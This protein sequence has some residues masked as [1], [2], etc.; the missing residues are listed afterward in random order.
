MGVGGR[1]YGGG[2]CM[3]QQYPVVV[4]VSEYGKKRRGKKNSREG[5][6]SVAIMEENNYLFRA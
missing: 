5:K 4:A 3:K 6:T 1:S 2:G